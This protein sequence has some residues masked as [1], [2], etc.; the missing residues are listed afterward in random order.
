MNGLRLQSESGDGDV[1]VAQRDIRRRYSEAL[2]HLL[3]FGMDLSGPVLAKLLLAAHHPLM[4]SPRDAGTT[5][6]A[7][8]KRHPDIVSTLEREHLTCHLRITDGGWTDSLEEI[9]TEL[10]SEIGLKSDD[11]NQV[12]AAL[13][14]I[15]T[16]ARRFP[17]EILTLLSP[18]L[19]EHLDK[20]VCSLSG[21]RA[22]W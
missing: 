4:Q 6:A 5:W 16:C 14:A 2:T 10:Q 1:R 12:T 8:L 17:A 21:V 20:C 22:V 13:V 9:V 3:P 11:S 15:T 18:F 19:H 7:F